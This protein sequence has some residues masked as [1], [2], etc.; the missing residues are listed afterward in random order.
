[1]STSREPK[2]FLACFIK[3]Y[4]LRHKQNN[5]IEGDFLGEHNVVKIV[6]HVSLA[7]S[8]SDEISVTYQPFFAI[9]LAGSP[10]I[11]QAEIVVKLISSTERSHSKFNNSL[12]EK[13][14]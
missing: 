7:R 4:H 5:K 10:I 14:K 3:A 1:M 13:H 12:V 11:P 8:M 2:R 6:D 9:E